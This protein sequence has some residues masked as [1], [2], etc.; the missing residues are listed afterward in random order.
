MTTRTQ[1]AR[2]ADRRRCQRVSDQLDAYVK[3]KR[4]KVWLKKEPSI[5]ICAIYQKYGLNAWDFYMYGNTEAAIAYREEQRKEQQRKYYE[6]QREKTGAYNPV[7]PRRSPTE[8]YMDMTDEEKWEAMQK[9]FEE[10][11]IKREVRAGT[12]CGICLKPFDCDTTD[13]ST[14]P[15]S[16]ITQHK[17]I[18]FH[19]SCVRMLNTTENDGEKVVENH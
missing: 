17:G 10:R 18:N 4:D 7:G 14:N 3:G 19:T 11:D 13:L 12:R 8:K 2:I 5:G 1:L 16:N 9:H 15:K 6:K